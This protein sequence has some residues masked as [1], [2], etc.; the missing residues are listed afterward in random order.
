VLEKS[1]ELRNSVSEATN[2]TQAK[3]RL[4]WGTQNRRNFRTPHQPECANDNALRD[5][6]RDYI[7]VVDKELG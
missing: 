5:F 1:F 3:A 2:P 7:V 6:A 4:E